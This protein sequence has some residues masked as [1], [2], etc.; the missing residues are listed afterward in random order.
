MA[1]KPKKVYLAFPT[2]TP[3][4]SFGGALKKMNA[5]D[6]AVAAGQGVLQRSGVAPKEIDAVILGHARQAG[7]GPNTARQVLY[8]LNI[9]EM[10]EAFTVNQACNSGLKALML[11]AQSVALGEATC[12]LAGG[13]ESMSNTPYFLMDARFGMRAG[14][15]QV[16]D[17]MYRDGFLCP[18]SGLLMGE[19]AENLAEKYLISRAQQD[20]YALQSQQRA[21]AAAARGAFGN[22]IVAIEKDG[23]KVLDVDE[24]PRKNC[25]L[26]NLQ[27]LK[28]VFKENGGVTAGNACGI[29][30]G[31]A[32]CLVGDAS[33]LKKLALTSQAAVV[34]VVDFLTVGVDPRFM[35][36]GPVSAVRKILERNGL[37][38]AQID[39]IELNEAFAAQVI[40]CDR[41]LKFDSERLNVNGGAI[42]LGH[43]IGAT[44]ARIVVSLCH[45]MQKRQSQWGLATLC[46][47]GGLGGAM[48]LRRVI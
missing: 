47:S 16:V 34:E 25:T 38:L 9:P 28:P 42:A 40:A 30:D 3:I 36:I 27:K 14:H 46:V 32:A 10:R 15:G 5:A 18:L 24:H 20:A 48:L 6:L 19:T 13:A 12:V 8:R 33:L 26:D 43:P 4:G 41:E 1:D 37:T 23:L 22:E 11:A 31:A 35:G 2:R 39:L 7:G 21:Q 17:G 45:E 29:T 44:G